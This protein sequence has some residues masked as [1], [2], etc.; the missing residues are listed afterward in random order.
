MIDC[1]GKRNSNT[2]GVKTQLIAF[3]KAPLCNLT[4]KP[5][6]FRRLALQLR[7]CRPETT[8]REGGGQQTLPHSWPSEFRRIIFKYLFRGHSSRLDFD[9]TYTLTY[10]LNQIVP[11][12]ASLADLP[13]IPAKIFSKSKTDFCFQKIHAPIQ[14]N[15]AYFANLD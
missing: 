14:L 2:L 8:V 1:N 7:G 3:P 6:G 15:V 9:R 10:L 13:I 11:R 12:P 5:F 4:Q